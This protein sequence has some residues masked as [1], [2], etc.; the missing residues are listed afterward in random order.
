LRR[1]HANR[2]WPRQDRALFT[3]LV[4]AEA[5]HEELQARSERSSTAPEWR[6]WRDA[7]LVPEA[8]MDMPRDRRLAWEADEGTHLLGQ[9]VELPLLTPLTLDG[10]AAAAA[11]YSQQRLVLDT[12]EEVRLLA[13]E[14]AVLRELGFPAG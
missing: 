2:D 13:E 5:L 7:Q 9:Q 1:S 14:T 12:G 11:R 8:V 3:A 4:T 6:P 10:V